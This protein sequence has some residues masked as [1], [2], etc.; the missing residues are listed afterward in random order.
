MHTPLCEASGPMLAQQYC[1]CMAVVYNDACSQTCQRPRAVTGETLLR[2]IR[3]RR[4]F[5]CGAKTAACTT[6]HKHIAAEIAVVETLPHTLGRAAKHQQNHLRHPKLRGVLSCGEGR[7]QFKVLVRL[8]NCAGASLM[9]CTK[10]GWIGVYTFAKFASALVNFSY[11]FVD[12]NTTFNDRPL[13]DLKIKC[14]QS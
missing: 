3:R 7:Q 2:L 1:S 4:V 11:K 12:G 6:S 10:L 14:V 5:S 13:T 8:A 9:H